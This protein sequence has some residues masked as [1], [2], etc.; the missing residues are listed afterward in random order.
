MRAIKSVPLSAPW[1]DERDEELVLETLR[2]GWI[3]LGPTGPRFERAMCDATGAA[4]NAFRCGETARLVLHYQNLAGRNLRN[5]QIDVGI[6]DAAGQR[7]AL[8]SSNLTSHGSFDLASD[9]STIEVRIDRLP[10]MPG[11][12]A[13]TLFFAVNGETADW[14]QNA[15]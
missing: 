12:Y 3:S 9:V 14:I 6:D 15:G 7:I 10:L 5:V 4:L 11:K 2:S 13:F 8:L 1:I